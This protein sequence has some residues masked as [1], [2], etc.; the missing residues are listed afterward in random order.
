MDFVDLASAEAH[1]SGALGRA[2]AAGLES[3]AVRFG[4][5]NVHNAMAVLVET[6][7]ESVQ[8]DGDGGALIGDL[9]SLTE[10]LESPSQVAVSAAHARWLAYLLWLERGDLGLAVARAEAGLRC[11]LGAPPT[12]MS[13]ERL[14]TWIEHFS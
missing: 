9:K 5:A 3:M 10:Y 12:P 1:R 2:A 8:A 7:G 11:T 4:A 6:M 14:A 13:V